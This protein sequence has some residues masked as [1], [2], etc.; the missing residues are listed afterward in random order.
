MNLS[1]WNKILFLVGGFT[2]GLKWS[3][4]ILFGYIGMFFDHFGCMLKFIGNTFTSINNDPDDDE[5]Y[6]SDQENHD[7]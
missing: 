4:T 7:Q 1:N 3:S 5:G 2:L 6:E